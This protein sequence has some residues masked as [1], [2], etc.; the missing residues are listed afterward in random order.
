MDKNEL[1]R[2]IISTLQTIYAEENKFYVK[3]SKF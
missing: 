3:E 1:A 2:K